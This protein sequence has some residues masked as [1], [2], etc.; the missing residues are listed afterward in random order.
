MIYNKDFLLFNLFPFLN[1]FYVQR[2]N[3]I[4]PEDLQLLLVKN[5]S[6][7]LYFPKGENGCGAREEEHICSYKNPILFLLEE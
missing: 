5:Q 4:S 7:H 3:S 1:T 6:R 2:Y